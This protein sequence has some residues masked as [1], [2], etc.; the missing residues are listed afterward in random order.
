MRSPFFKVL[1]ALFS[2]AVSTGKYCAL[3]VVSKVMNSS[4][5]K[6]SRFIITVNA[7][8]HKENVSCKQA[9]PFGRPPT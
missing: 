4:V 3:A 2:L 6:I 9:I 7:K 1:Y 8:F 5:A